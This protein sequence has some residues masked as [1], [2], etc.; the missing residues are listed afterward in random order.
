M[1]DDFGYLNARIRVRRSQLLSEGFFRE[2]LNLSFSELVKVLGESIYGPDITGGSLSDLDRAAT[3]HLNRTVADLP[4]LVSG[5]AREAVVLLLMRADLAN[6]KTILR[7]KSLGRSVEEITGHLGGGT[8]PQGL[9][10]AMAEAPD[11]PSLAQI[12]SL[13]EH[14]L[15]AALR[16]ASRDDPQ[17]LKTEVSLDPI[18]YREASFRAGVLGQPYLVDYIRFEIDAMNLA[19]G[20]K[21]SATGFE[22]PP[23]RFFLR[24]GRHVGLLLFK[25]LAG[26]GAAALEELSHTEF[27]RLGDVRNLTA[28]ERGLRCITL[29][30][31]REEAND[32][33]GAGFVIDYIRRKEWEA[34]RIRLLARRAY[35]NLPPASVEQEVFCS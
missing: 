19:T 2:A 35:H 10:R 3:A 5:K 33:L 16:E 24:G 26:G 27:G 29:A 13:V 25:Q 31:A 14:P 34:A 28:L 4:R 11:A 17:S 8:L 20:V 32:V 12:L 18:F 6:V 1:V 9:Y 22:G 23:D 7:E 30:K 21:L 15:A